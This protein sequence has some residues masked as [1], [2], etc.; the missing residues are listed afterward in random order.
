MG[1]TFELYVKSTS[2][3]EGLPL[4]SFERLGAEWN[5]ESLR[6][7]FGE[8]AEARTLDV[9]GWTD[10]HFGSRCPVHVVKARHGDFVGFL[11]Y[12]GNS[13]VRI[14]DTDDADG[15]D[16]LPPGWGTPLVWVADVADLPLPVR[17]VV[18]QELCERCGAALELNAS[19]YHVDMGQSV[20]LCENCAAGDD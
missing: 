20:W 18:T 10:L 6:L 1:K 17:D 8:G 19:P 4:Q 7:P 14:L 11:V 15:V 16:H 2:N 12:G 13:G 9:V 3:C 5:G